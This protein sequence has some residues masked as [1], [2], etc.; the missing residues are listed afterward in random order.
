MLHAAVA[1]VHGCGV[2]ESMKKI[3]KGRQH[4]CIYPTKKNGSSKYSHVDA[5]ESFFATYRKDD[6]VPY[7]TKTSIPLV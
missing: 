6:G 2:M 1:T 4:A 7:C 3:L 5:G